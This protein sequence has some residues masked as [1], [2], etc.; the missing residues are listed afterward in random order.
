MDVKTVRKL[1]CYNKPELVEVK[2]RIG[3]QVI[4]NL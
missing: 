3:E 4:D 1:E 2:C